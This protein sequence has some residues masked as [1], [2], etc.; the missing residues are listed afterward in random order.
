MIY[1]IQANEGGPIK[2]G[3]SVRLSLRI[4]QLAKEERRTIRVLGIMPGSYA[5]EAALHRRF[6]DILDHGEWFR[7]E[8]ALLNLI[9]QE[10]SPWDGKDDKP[11]GS[12]ARITGD[13]LTK[14]K[15]VSADRDMK[16]SDYLNSI[17]RPLVERDWLELGQ[18]IQESTAQPVQ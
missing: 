16:I 11:N 2:I 5:D 3:T 10:T 1:F 4:K 7:P 12:M 18:K 8:P 13:V 14:A 17:L 15:I 6:R 9:E